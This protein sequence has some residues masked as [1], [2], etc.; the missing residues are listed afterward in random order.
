[1]WNV[2]GTGE[3]YTGFWW[4][5]LRE[6]VYLGDPGVVARIILKRIFRKGNGVEC[7]GL[8]LFTIGRGEGFYGMG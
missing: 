2:W 6:G 8:T 4:G 1:M 3:V 5:N 7:T